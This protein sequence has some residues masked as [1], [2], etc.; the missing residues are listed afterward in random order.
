MK[1]QLASYIDSEQKEKTQLSYCS[2]YGRTCGRGM[3]WMCL[4]SY[5]CYVRHSKRMR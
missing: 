4:G 3:Q 1:I 5:R 2:R